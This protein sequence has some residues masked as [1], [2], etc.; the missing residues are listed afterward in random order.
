M[1]LQAFPTEKTMERV[2][3]LLDYAGSHKE[4]VLT[5]YASDMVLAVHSNVG[6]LNESKLRS[7]VGGHF[8]IMCYLRWK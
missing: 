8:K 1:H 3:Q 7:Q 2:R 6:Y 5:Y 4:A